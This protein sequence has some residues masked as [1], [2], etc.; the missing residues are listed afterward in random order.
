MS[1]G[2]HAA[3]QRERRRYFRIDDRVGLDLAQITVADEAQVIADFPRASA[4]FGLVNDLRAVRDA[5][6]PQRRSLERRFPTVASY[7]AVLERQIETLAFAL[8]ERDG[9]PVAPNQLINLSAQGFCFET[10][11]DFSVGSLV[12]VRLTLFPDRSRIKAL[13]RVISTDSGESGKETA[14][15]FTHLREADREAIIRHVHALQRRRLLAEGEGGAE[16][17]P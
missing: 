1:E 3:S 8:D 12:E 6:L 13:A 14:F 5:H 15:D 17:A 4:R 9:G 11:S 7:A 16:D 2:Q 10:D